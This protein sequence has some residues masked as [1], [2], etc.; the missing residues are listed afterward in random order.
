MS[1]HTFSSWPRCCPPWHFGMLVPMRTA[2]LSS[3]ILADQRHRSAMWLRQNA[4][5]RTLQ[6]PCSISSTAGRREDVEPRPAL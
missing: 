1:M 3:V 5:G 2:P 6:R 4:S